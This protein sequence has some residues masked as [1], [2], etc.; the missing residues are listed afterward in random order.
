MLS[1]GQ[2]YTITGIIIHHIEERLH[3]II[4]EDM[5]IIIGVHS[6]VNLVDTLEKYLYIEMTIEEVQDNIIRDFKDKDWMQI[7]QKLINIGLDI[8]PIDEQYKTEESLSPGCQ[9]KVWINGTKDLNGN[10]NYVYGSESS[11]V[12]G[13]LYLLISVV[14]GRQPQQIIDC[15]FHFIRD[16]GLADQITTL[17]GNG[18]GL[19]IDKIYNTAKSLVWIYQAFLLIIM[20]ENFSSKLMLVW[21]NNSW[22][23][24]SLYISL[25][26]LSYICK[27]TIIDYIIHPSWTIFAFSINTPLL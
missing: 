13:I 9:N 3:Q 4:I 18:M 14:N 20:F 21:Y 11:I 1:I 25:L 12:R 6:I 8:E 16:I 23:S 10:V 26:R 19:I 24:I 27:V 5:F 7:Y 17:R 15:D 2:A 22:V